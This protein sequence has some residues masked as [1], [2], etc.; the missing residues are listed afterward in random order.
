MI[1]VMII[2]DDPMVRAINSKFL[3]KI[4]DFHLVKAV[5]N[6]SDAKQF[7]SQEIIDLIL[8]DIYLPNENGIDLLKWLRNEEIKTDVILITADNTSKRILESFRYGAVDYLIKPFTLERFIETMNDFKKRY[9]GL[10]NL[11]IIGQNELDKCICKSV[12]PEKEVEASEDDF[13]KGINK[14]T[15]KIIWDEVEKSTEKYLTAKKLSEKTGVARVTVRKYLEYMEKEGKLK[16]I[17]KYGKVGRPQ[18][19]YLIVL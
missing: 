4:D 9:N 14:Y 5:S 17:L 19:K 13:E 18:H 6:L 3:E 16:K 1:K 10:N 15:Y 8:L 12:A 7:I 2:E 11:E